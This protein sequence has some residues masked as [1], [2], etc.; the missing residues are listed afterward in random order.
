MNSVVSSEG[1]IRPPADRLL[2]TGTGRAKVPTMPVTPEE[3]AEKAMEM[4]TESRAQL[5]ELLVES[6]DP[7]E[8]AGIE[9]KWAAEAKRRR[10]EVRSGAVKSIPADEVAREV[11]ESLK[12]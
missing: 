6:L 5:A 9:R 8:L 10:D 11:R 12:R 7:A 4:P 1:V 2:D 3:L